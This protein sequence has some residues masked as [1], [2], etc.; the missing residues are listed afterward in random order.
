M[1][2]C[3]KDKGYGARTGEVSADMILDFG[4][5]WT[6][7]GDGVDRGL[8]LSLRFLSLGLIPVLQVTQNAVSGLGKE[9]RA[10][11]S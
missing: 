3:G 11:N 5:K 7:T 9:E 8:T 10:A 2:N 4:L 1:Q 6:I